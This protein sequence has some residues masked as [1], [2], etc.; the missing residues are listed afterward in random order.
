M[1]FGIKNDCQCN[2]ISYTL[3]VT[4]VFKS[5]YFEDK[6]EKQISNFPAR[7]GGHHDD[8]PVSQ[9]LK[10]IKKKTANNESNDNEF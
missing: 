4:S 7:W 3:L 6:K 2:Y 5:A 8:P 9:I 10:I 1:Y